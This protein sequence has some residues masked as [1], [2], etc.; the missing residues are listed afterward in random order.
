MTWIITTNNSDARKV[1]SFDDARSELL[2]RISGYVVE[3]QRAND[4]HAD[5]AGSLEIR[6]SGETSRI[7][8]ERPL[9]ND[10]ICVFSRFGEN[11]AIINTEFAITRDDPRMYGTRRKFGVD[12][13]GIFA[14]TSFRWFDD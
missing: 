2:R 14:E 4:D 10:V 6:I 5:A 11:H 12:D 13:R 9:P 3:Q 7:A 8:K 1:R